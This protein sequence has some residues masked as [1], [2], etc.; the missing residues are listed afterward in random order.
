LQNPKGLGTL[1]AV[2]RWHYVAI[3]LAV[4]VGLGYFFFHRGGAGLASVPAGSSVSGGGYSSVT[5]VTEP[6]VRAARMAWQTV[7]RP[8]DGFKIEMPGES[9]DLQ[10]PAYNEMGTTEPVKMLFASPDADTT[11][12]IAWEDDP[13]VARVNNRAPEKTLDMA[14]DG[15]LARTQT[16]LAN[17]SKGMAGGYPSRDI[18]AHNA[19]G[20]VLNARMI[21]AND[22]LYLIMALYPSSTV[23]REQDVVRYFNSFTPSRTPDQTLPR[24][25]PKGT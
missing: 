18:A 16:T 11:F 9:R 8:D 2:K 25:S 5:D 4:A 24:A 1:V 12:A 14:R 10:V 19:Q 6:A 7:D 23:R 3:G 15:M 21:Y 17:E 22:R 13:P 20:G